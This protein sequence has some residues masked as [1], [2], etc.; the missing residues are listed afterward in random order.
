MKKKMIV[1][2][3]M[4]EGFV[5]FGNLADRGI[6]R[7]VPAT[8]ALVKSGIENGDVVVAFKDTHAPDDVEFQDY[9]PHCVR[10]TSECELI[11]EL[12]PF[13][14]QMIVIEKNTTNGFKTAEFRKLIEENDFDEIS[15]AGCCTDI[16][17]AN[18]LEGLHE[19]LQNA[20]RKTKISVM[21]NA[22]DTFNAP[23]HNADE[24]NLKYLKRFATDYNAKLILPSAS[25]KSHTKGVEND[26]TKKSG[27][28]L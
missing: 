2:V 12:R 16:C 1:I 18:F 4:V 25:G 24:V 20:G 27:K 23:N 17:V 8:V 3:D 15:V 5:N 11:P 26:K 19:Y 14:E 13:E 9:P 7:I 10:G 22:V 6:N 28:S 21:A